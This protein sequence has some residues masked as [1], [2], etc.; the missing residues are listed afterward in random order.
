MAGG[1]STPAICSRSKS[2][3]SSSPALTTMCRIPAVVDQQPR[4]AEPVAG[5]G[6]DRQQPIGLPA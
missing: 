5:L 2:S 1:A 4:Q 3:C 6:Q